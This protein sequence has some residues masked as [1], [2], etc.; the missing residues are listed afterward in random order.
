V[1][2][3]VAGGIVC[4]PVLTAT[5]RVRIEGLRTVSL[6]TAKGWIEPQ[7]TFIDSTGVSMARADDVAYFLENALRDRG[8]RDA[9]VE[10]Q[11]AGE[12]EDRHIVL[13]VDEGESLTVVSYVIT[14]NSALEDVAVIELL[15][16][17][18]R[19]RLSLKPADAIP[20]VRSDLEAGLSGLEQ[21]YALLGFSGAAS[22]M[23][24]ETVPGGARVNLVI[25]EGV[26]A[27]TGAID[28]GEAPAAFFEGKFAKL[29]EEFTGKNFHPGLVANLDSR[30]RALAVNAGYSEVNVTIE[31][32]DRRPG[33]EGGEIVDLVAMVEWGQPSTISGV[34]VSGNEKVRDVF[35]E[36]H[37]SS[38]VGAP[39]SPKDSA[40]AVDDLLKTGAFETVR[41]EP[42][43]GE[44]GSFHLDI[45]VEEAYSRTLGIFGGFTN[46]EGP[47]GGFVF[48]NLNLF[49]AVRTVDS[50]I[51]FSRRGAKGEVEYRDPWFL[52]RDVEFGAGIFGQ[53]RQEEGYEKWETGGN[54]EF[55]KRLGP[56]ERTSATL[57]GRAS[58]T[59]VQDSEI[60]D[61]F[62]G[63]TE[64]FTHFAGLSLTRDRRDDPHN[65]RKGFLLQGAVS[66][67]SSG[68]G[69]EVEFV[70]LTAR[71]GWYHPVGT[72]NFRL[73]TRVGSISPIGDTDEIPI[74]LR[75]FNGGPQ[76]VRSFQERALGP[77]D[78]TSGH[79]IG[80]EFYSVFNAEY[81][82]PL[83][84]FEGLS[85]VFFGDAGNLIIDAG[86]RGLNDM[87]YAIGPG[88]RYRTP[89][90]PVRIEY[91]LNPDP[92]PGEPDGTLHFGFGFTY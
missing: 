46:Y 71:A 86:D 82:I 11:L 81:E 2:T 74:D 77:R 30:V 91:G 23:E 48:S 92:R 65:P 4:S 19:K 59:E 63:D 85:F 39:Y 35:F 40:G 75:F 13:T 80:G 42:V 1:V 51:E 53:N 61:R 38:L 72:H 52:N 29:E 62:L 90:G 20:L 66:A 31:E 58:Y 27:Q 24:I 87:R 60:A 76:T 15:E 73:S 10:W 33:P 54:Y 36:N 47:V 14:G 44:D 68:L 69:S 49:G 28:F 5:E 8:F 25:E 37:F 21:F 41:M 45:E 83:E 3:L 26:S 50:R 84:R 6:D 78:P 18:T 7:L 70:K 79:E 34:S 88:L 89:I 67:A 43:K 56:E 16:A 12:T 32:A 57:F 55:T 9:S 64:Y 22:E 17:A